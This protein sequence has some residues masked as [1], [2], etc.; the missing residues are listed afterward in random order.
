MALSLYL[1]AGLIG[2]AAHL[3]VF[4]RGEWHLLAP[5]VVL[6]HIV[7][8]WVLL[9]VR[10][11]SSIRQE[12]IAAVV[13]PI[14]ISMSY[15]IGIIGSISVYRLFFHRLRAFPGPRMAAWTKLWH[16]Y[17]CRDFRNHL[18]LDELHHKYGSFVRTGA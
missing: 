4:I 2:V 14:C 1:Q 13:E 3:G 9:T 12:G 8:F 10:A 7:M 18:K 5:V 6:A 11:F 15:L 16:V 17:E